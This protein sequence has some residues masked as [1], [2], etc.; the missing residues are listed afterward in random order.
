MA[1]PPH[2]KEREKRVKADI[3]CVFTFDWYQAVTAAVQ[4]GEATEENMELQLL[5]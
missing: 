3:K 5:G 2:F 4:N 1:Y